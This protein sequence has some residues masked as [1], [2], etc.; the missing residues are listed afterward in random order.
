MNKKKNW[1]QVLREMKEKKDQW[2]ILLLVGI[3]LIVIAMPVSN[4]ERSGR[5]KTGNGEVS[6]E[7]DE[8]ARESL[9]GDGYARDL[10][11][12]LEN[13]LT[14]VRGVGNVSVMITLSSS[15]EKVVE[16]DRE[17]SSRKEGGL[18]DSSSAEVSV[19]SGGSGEEIPYVK[20]E[21]SPEIEGVLVIADGG[22]NAVVIE[23]ITEAVQALFRVDTHKI[24]V[25]KRS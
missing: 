1:K 17:I 24:K 2:L 9:S 22:E 8:S 25:M 23:N 16:K 11:R 18:T 14:K 3:L 10:E 19:Y 7:N 21:L 6:A 12:R 20:K 5:G 13:A 4:E 15:T